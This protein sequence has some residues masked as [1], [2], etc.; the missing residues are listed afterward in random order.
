MVGVRL[1]MAIS[2]Q[3]LGCASVAAALLA[4]TTVA[5][6]CSRSA[7]PPRRCRSSV[8]QRLVDSFVKKSGMV[9][10]ECGDVG[11]LE[12]AAASGCRPSHLA[13]S[14]HTIEGTPAYFDYFVLRGGKDCQITVFGDYSDDYWGGCMVGRRACPSVVAARSDDPDRQGCSPRE[15]LHKPRT[16]PPPLLDARPPT[17]G[18]ALAFVLGG[19][20]C[21]LNFWL[22]FA[23]HPLHRLRHGPTARPPNM[24]GIPLFGSLAVGLSLLALHDRTWALTVGIPLCLLDTGG[25]HW[26]AGMFIWRRWSRK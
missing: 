10:A 21:L 7:G 5:G 14:F 9:F 22:S 20:L 8:G 3:R 6:G 12:Q 13:E 25:I 16:C 19:L 24:S 17:L 1:A 15:V 11:C 18:A 26:A 2:Y 23:R 4:L